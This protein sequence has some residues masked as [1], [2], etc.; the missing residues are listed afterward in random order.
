MSCRSP[1]K[2][3]SG[4]SERIMKQLKNHVNNLHQETIHQ[5]LACLRRLI[6]L[7]LLKMKKLY[8]DL[9]Y[10]VIKTEIFEEIYFFIYFIVSIIEYSLKMMHYGVNLS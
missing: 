3:T 8:S 5:N 7:K 2:A 10:D 9:S 1:P 4:I 6:L